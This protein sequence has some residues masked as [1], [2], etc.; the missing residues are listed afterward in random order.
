MVDKPNTTRVSD[1]T[2]LW[3]NEGWLYL[4]VTLGLFLRKVAGRGMA[5][6]LTTGLVLDCLNA[7]LK[8]RDVA[9]GLIHHSDR[10]REYAARGLERSMLCGVFV[11]A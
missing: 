6:R 4:A 9:D 2:Y 11:K 8:S 1:V 10:G 5:E 7:A 3:T